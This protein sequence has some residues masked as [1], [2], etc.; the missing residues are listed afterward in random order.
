[1]CD[2]SGCVEVCVCERVIV[3][4]NVCVRARALTSA[5]LLV[6]N[7]K[8]RKDSLA[9]GEL[10]V[11]LAETLRADRPL[12]GPGSSPGFGGPG[13]AVRSEAGG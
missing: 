7:T 2:V 1:M 9:R 12:L 10:E 6:L 5:L 8:L 13:I 4:V 11:P 3:C